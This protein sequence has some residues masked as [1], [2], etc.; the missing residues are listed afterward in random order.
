MEGK[1]GGQ[2]RA[3]TPRTAA[4]PATAQQRPQEAKEATA[5]P[6]I[7]YEDFA[8]L[9]LRVAKILD[10]EKVEGSDR[11]LKLRVRAGTQ[12]R[13]LVAGIAEYYAPDE[14]LGRKII[15]VANLGPRKIRGEESQG[16]LLAAVQEEGG[17][18]AGLCLATV[19]DAEFPDGC[20]LS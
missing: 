17:K 18:L 6:A 15:I 14:L 1:E 11:L 4:A 2:G 8:K 16:M 10:A 20:A 9:D 3:Q 7:A 19:D 5:K 12:E 13:Q